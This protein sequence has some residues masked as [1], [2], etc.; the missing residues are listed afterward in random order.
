MKL[1][2]V[3]IVNY[4]SWNTL[5]ECLNSLLQFSS[6]KYSLEIIVVDNCSNDDMLE[7]FKNKFP[8]IQFILNS[9][10]NGFANGCN[11][12]AQNATSDYFLF[13]NPDTTV[14]KIN[15]ETFFD[16]YLQDNH[17][18]L[19]CLQINEHGNYYNQYNFLPKFVT[20][21]GLHRAIYRFL[22]RKKITKKLNENENYFYPEWITGAVVL[23]SKKWFDLIGG[24]NEDYWMY[25]EDVD[26]SNKVIKNNG[27][28]AV[29]KKAVLF[30]KHGGASRININTKAI[31]KTEVIISKHTY[32]QNNFPKITAFFLHLR[33]ILGV[34]LEKLIL[35]IVSIPLFFNQKL[36]VNRL[37]LKRYISYLWNALLNNTFIS[38]RAMNYKKNKV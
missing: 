19:S 24:W 1:F 3:L 16:Y 29:L 28:V 10:N 20:F 11:L 38:P 25:L 6:E 5:E 14:D 17:A 35:S 27:S 12:A 22:F 33:L 23:I 7:Q 26:F 21:F 15:L 13:L 34:I 30:H 4:K 2:S 8:L 32:I 31:T 37:V 36:K 18:L 9:G